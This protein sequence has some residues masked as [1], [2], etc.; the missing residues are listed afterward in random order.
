MISDS[1]VYCRSASMTDTVD[2]KKYAL[3]S[4]AARIAYFSEESKIAGVCDIAQSAQNIEISSCQSLPLYF[5]ADCYPHHIE[6]TRESGFSIK[7]KNLQKTNAGLN[8]TRF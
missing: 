3:V 4:R 5:S 7:Y 1:S 2:N 8:T 6:A